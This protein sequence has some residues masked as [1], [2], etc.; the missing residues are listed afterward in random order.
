MLA[1]M[2]PPAHLAA[3]VAL[4][5]ALACSKPASPPEGAP[6]PEPSTEPDPVAEPEPSADP[7]PDPVPGAEPD[8][9][10]GAEPTPEPGADPDPSDQVATKTCQKDADCVLTRFAG[11]CDCCGCTQDAYAI[12]RTEL[13]EKEKI[14]SRVRCNMSK[15]AAV[16]CAPCPEDPPTGKAVCQANR[17]VAR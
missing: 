4:A 9:E 3:L 11:C 10:P 12:H 13:A 7:E 17:C 6:A 1:A 5:L 2:K 15:C 8:P 16:L 14:C